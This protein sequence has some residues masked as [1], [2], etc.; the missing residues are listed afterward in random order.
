MVKKLLLPAEV[1]TYYIIPTLRRYIA[2]YLIAGG[3]KQKDVAAILQVNT[4]AISQ[5]HSEKRGHAIDFSPAVKVEIQRSVSRILS[6]ESYLREVQRLLSFIRRRNEL[7]RIHKQF[8]YVPA[9][10]TPDTMG[11]HLTAVGG[12]KV[13]N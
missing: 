6:S 7:C 9:D 10:C 5:Y 1:E 13:W 12:C 4:A 8:S 11:C 3:M 2:E